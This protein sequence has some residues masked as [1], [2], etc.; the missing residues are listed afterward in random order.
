MQ[1]KNLCKARA[2]A[3]SS[4]I[5]KKVLFSM[6]I[7]K[8]IDWQF[9]RFFVVKSFT[10]SSIYHSAAFYNLLEITLHT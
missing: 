7:N 9:L 1:K 2:N 8:I 10:N 5:L 6:N 4:N 3:S